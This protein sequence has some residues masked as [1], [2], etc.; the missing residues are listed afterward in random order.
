MF[1]LTCSLR[2]CIVN[3]NEGYILNM[4]ASD[5]RFVCELCCV[6]RACLSVCECIG[7]CVVCVSCVR[8]R[9]FPRLATCSECPSMCGM[10]EI[11]FR[12]TPLGLMGIL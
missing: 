5:K 10:S 8:V 7:V 12:L 3:S 4:N 6:L 11:P 1:V 9:Y 2:L